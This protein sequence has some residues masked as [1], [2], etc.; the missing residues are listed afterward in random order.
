M[1][2]YFLHKVKHLLKLVTEV[3]PVSL[4]VTPPSAAPGRIC[5]INLKCPQRGLMSTHLTLSVEDIRCARLPAHR[6]V[7]LATSHF[8]VAMSNAGAVIFS[9]GSAKLM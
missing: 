7:D 4:L 1:D 5:I 6:A 2:R 9:A 8:C 3:S